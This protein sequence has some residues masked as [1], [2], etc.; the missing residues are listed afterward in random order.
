MAWESRNIEK[1]DRSL[2]LLPCFPW[3]HLCCVHLYRFS[4]SVSISAFTSV[5]LPPLLSFAFNS[6]TYLER[7][8]WWLK[9][10][11]ITHSGLIFPTEKYRRFHT[12]KLQNKLRTKEGFILALLIHETDIYQHAKFKP[13]QGLL[14]HLLCLCSFLGNSCDPMPIAKPNFHPRSNEQRST[15]THTV[16]YACWNKHLH[17]LTCNSF[18]A[19][20]KSGKVQMLRCETFWPISCSDFQYWVKNIFGNIWPSSFN[21]N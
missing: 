13:K 5:L 15:H 2:S 10:D 16:Q 14:L 1:T 12:D 8:H 21:K 3:L 18:H 9:W 11:W 6:A 17:I 19:R 4:S 20:V 7:P